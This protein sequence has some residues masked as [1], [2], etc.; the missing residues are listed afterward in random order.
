MKLLRTH[1]RVNPRDS[2]GQGLDAVITL[3]LF[4]GVGFFVDRWLGTTPWMMVALT[5]VAA[6]GLFY[7]M[8]AQYFARM[9]AHDAERAAARAAGPDGR[10]AGDTGAPQP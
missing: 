10:R 7:K 4:F 1:V 5:L 9:D 6:V 8:R 3:V 2:L